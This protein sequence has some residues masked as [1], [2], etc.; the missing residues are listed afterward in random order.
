MVERSNRSR[1]LGFDEGQTGAFKVEIKS[2]NS[3]SI[4][5]LE[6]RCEPRKRLTALL[7][8]VGAARFGRG[9]LVA[10]TGQGVL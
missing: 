10:S 8:L 5:D 2:E 7:F 3:V 9:K 6:R 1:I 4:G